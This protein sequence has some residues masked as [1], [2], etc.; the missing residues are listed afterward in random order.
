MSAEHPARELTNEELMELVRQRG[1]ATV[2]PQT[3]TPAPQPAVPQTTLADKLK[4]LP[5]TVASA[6]RQARSCNFLP[7]ATK[8]A[9]LDVII[10]HILTTGG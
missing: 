4:A 3:P 8:T 6:A 5:E 9:L 10:D 2:A 1:L 7:Q